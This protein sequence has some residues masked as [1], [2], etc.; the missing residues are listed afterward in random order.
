MR[1]RRGRSAPSGRYHSRSQWVCGIRWKTRPPFSESGLSGRLCSRLLTRISVATFVKRNQI[2]IDGQTT[3]PREYFTSPELF[4]QE[5]ENIFY[6][7]WLCVGRADQLPN[8]G[9][10]F[11]QEVGRESVIVLK[12]EGGTFRAYYNV[13]R[14]RG[15]RLCEEHSGQFSETITCPYHLWAYGL[16]GRLIGAPST[17]DIKGIQ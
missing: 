3:L 1:T 11:V 5:L 4:A 15:T 10:Y 9:D 13:C 16:D 8:P 7:R 12:D 2:N 6:R 17:H 14:H